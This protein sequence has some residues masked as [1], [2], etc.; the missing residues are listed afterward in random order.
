MVDIRSIKAKGVLGLALIQNIL[1]AP[2]GRRGA[3]AWLARLAQ[4]DL[5]S[6]P[7][8]TWERAEQTSRCIACG[9]C[10]SVAVELE[11]ISRFFTA[12]GRRPQDAPLALAEAERVREH[13]EEITRVCPAGLDPAAVLTLIEAHAEGLLGS[14]SM[15]P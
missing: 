14:N 8:C 5:A 2:F 11:G 7:A 9:L 10:E 15:T 4:E 12:A 1:S 13:M 3:Q 6:T